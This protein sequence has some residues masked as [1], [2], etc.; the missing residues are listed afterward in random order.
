MLHLSNK[1]DFYIMDMSLNY[2]EEYMRL[3]GYIL[4]K[5]E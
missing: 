4:Y 5:G 2:E 3:E 1:I